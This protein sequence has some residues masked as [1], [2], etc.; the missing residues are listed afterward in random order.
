MIVVFLLCWHIL[1]N[2]AI[3]RYIYAIGGNE[4]AAKLSG[5]NVKK[6]KAIIVSALSRI[7]SLRRK[8]ETIKSM[9]KTKLAAKIRYIPTFARDKRVKK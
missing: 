2:M 5:L 3:G 6:I 1:R 4:E 9:M 8:N 7:H